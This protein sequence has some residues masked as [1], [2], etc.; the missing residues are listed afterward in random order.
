MYSKISIL[1]VALW[2]TAC[3]TLPEPIQV[4]DGV[5]LISYENA[6]SS[7]QEAVGQK[8]RWGGVIAKIENKP[9]NTMLELVYYPL[10]GYGRPLADDESI[11]RFRV[12]V[13][14]FMDPMVYQ[15]GRTMTF[16]G[17]FSGL[18]EGLVGEHQYVFPALN[19]SGYYLWK[20]IE[21]VDVNMISVWP[22][23]YWRYGGYYNSPFHNRVIIRSTHHTRSN[24]TPVRKTA[25]DE[26]RNR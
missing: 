22:Y 14:G 17:D 26:P 23:D 24:K 25:K 18:E 21:H 6:A 12:Y 19:V 16:T 15:K 20:K 3:S 1:L 11:G 9:E 5:Q 7:T 4:P 13:N 8:A 10:T 2:I